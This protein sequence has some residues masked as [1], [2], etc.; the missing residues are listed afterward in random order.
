MLGEVQSIG[1]VLLAGAVLLAGFFSYVYQQKRQEYLVAWAVAWF[2]I[3]CYFVRPAL[4]YSFD[5]IPWFSVD[6]WI[7]SLALL[8]FYCS[9]RLYARL[10]IPFAAVVIAGVVALAWSVGYVAGWVPVHLGLGVALGFFVVAHTFW[11]EGS[12]EESRA[13]QLL[14][15]AFV[16]SGILRLLMVFQPRIG[17]LKDHASAAFCIAAGNVRRRFDVD[18]RL[19]RRAPPHRTKHAGALESESGD[20]EFCRRRN[21]EDAGAGSR[22]GTECGTHSGRRLDPHYADDRGPTSIVATGMS[23]SF[24]TETQQDRSRRLHRKPGRAHGRSGGASRS[25][26]RFEL[27]GTGKRKIFPPGAADRF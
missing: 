15:F 20:V 3:A 4:G 23:D 2:L 24:S 27:G 8:A 14:A 16:G 21:T 13:D 1:I 11:H 25:G 18:G 22:P 19:R 6:E 10:K 7:L 26:A 5:S 9:A 17:A 12:N